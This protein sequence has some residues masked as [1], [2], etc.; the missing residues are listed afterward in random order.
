VASMSAATAA[1]LGLCLFGV[2][3]ALTF[4]ASPALVR[5][6]RTASALALPVPVLSVCEQPG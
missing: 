2:L 3:C 1:G 6:L 4:I 5:R